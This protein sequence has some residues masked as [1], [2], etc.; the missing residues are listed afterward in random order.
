MPASNLPIL[1]PV[2]GAFIVFMAVV[3][4]VHLWC[5]MEPK[6]DDVSRQ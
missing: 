6:K 2:I 5:A 1:L 4:G 3:G